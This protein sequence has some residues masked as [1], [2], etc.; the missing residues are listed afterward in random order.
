[1]VEP[2]ERLALLDRLGE[3]DVPRPDPAD[4]IVA[5]IEVGGVLGEDLR[6]LAGEARPRA[7]AAQGR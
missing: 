1:M 7:S 4:Q 6:R 5:V 2:V 3:A